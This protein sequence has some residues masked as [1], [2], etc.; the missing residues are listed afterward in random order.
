VLELLFPARCVGCGRRG[1]L[2]CD[3]CRADLPRLANVC[4]RCALPRGVTRS[5]C[6]GCSQLSPALASL[7]A[8]CAFEGAARSAVHALKFRG[9]RT[10][11]PVLGEVMREY[12]RTSPLRVDLVVPVP[13]APG[14]QR[15]RGYNQAHLLA[16]QVAPVV[17]GVLDPHVLE[18]GDR[19]AQS[20]LGAADRMANLATAIRVRRGM[21]E[22]RVLV[23]DDVATTG[24]TVSAC[25]EALASAGASNVRALV[26]A[27]DL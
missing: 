7:R 9:G 5:A 12:L 1:R 17:G 18:R 15:E 23:V 24:A 25:A 16:E 22:Q 26:F 20:T 3:G 19:P 21:S 8:V 13:S 10:L 4:R 14:R 6:R 27:R 2:L 11:A